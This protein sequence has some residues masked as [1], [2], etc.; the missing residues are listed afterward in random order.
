MVDRSAY[1]LGIRTSS[2]DPNLKLHAR[3]MACGVVIGAGDPPGPV[4]RRRI[5][6]V[7]WSVFEAA[8]LKARRST[9]VASLARM[10]WGAMRHDPA[11]QGLHFV[12]V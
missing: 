2:D 8:L 6:E 5:T 4:K 7:A 10:G 12:P 9:K 3:F 1:P 11:V